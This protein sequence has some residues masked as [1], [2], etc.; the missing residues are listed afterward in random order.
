MRFPMHRLLQLKSVWADKHKAW[1]HGVRKLEWAL[2]HMEGE[3]CGRLSAPNAACC[4]LAAARCEL[5]LSR[6]ETPAA[7]E[8]ALCLSIPKKREGRQ[9][10]TAAM[11]NKH[12][13]LHSP[14]CAALAE[15]AAIICRIWGL[16]KG[17]TINEKAG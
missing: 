14:M 3:S 8:P 2:A 5:I 4:A 7:R 13:E 17:F 9:C 11:K 1:V 6:L 15:L 12:H 10:A 16:R